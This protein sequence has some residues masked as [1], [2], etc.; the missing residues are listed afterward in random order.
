MTNCKQLYE[1]IQYLDRIY[2][3]YAP[4]AVVGYQQTV[5]EKA[6]D[7]QN[8]CRRA[9]FERNRLIQ[10]MKDKVYDE[11]EDLL[12]EKKSDEVKKKKTNVKRTK[13]VD[14]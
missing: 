3:R 12:N 13:K 10:M 1:Y 4:D 14:K 7:A 2:D 9:S 6:I 11:I 8:Q 5:T